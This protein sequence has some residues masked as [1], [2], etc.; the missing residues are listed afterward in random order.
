MRVFKTLRL[1]KFYRRWSLAEA[2]KELGEYEPDFDDGP[3]NVSE[4]GNLFAGET[5]GLEESV[6]VHLIQANSNLVDD[7]YVSKWMKD[8]SFELME[9]KHAL[10]IGLQYPE[11]QKDNSIWT[12]GSVRNRFVFVLGSKQ[13]AG[14]PV[15]IRRTFSVT[16]RGHFF[17]G[18]CLFGAVRAPAK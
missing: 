2:L 8:N 4:V 12:L 1:F 10:A 13:N 7:S 11:E 5:V 17:G 15:Y 18:G 14:Q 9:L 3:R 6:D 16:R